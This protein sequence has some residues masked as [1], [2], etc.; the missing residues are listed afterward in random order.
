[1]SE[2]RDDEADEITAHWWRRVHCCVTPDVIHCHVTLSTSA[3]DVMP[4]SSVM[5]ASAVMMM[6]MMMTM[7]MMITTTM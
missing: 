1:M 5:H 2:V 6:M 7:M 3:T 4:A